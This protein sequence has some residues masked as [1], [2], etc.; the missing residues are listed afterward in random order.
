MSLRIALFLLVLLV[1]VST[2]GYAEE[3]E[4]IEKVVTTGIG[5]D[6][7]RAKQNAIRNA[8]EQVIGSYVSSDT[9][10]KNSQLLK[11]EILSY[12]GGYLKEMKIISQGQNDDGLFAVQIEAVVVSTKLKRKIESLNIATKKVEGKSLFGEAASKINEQKDASGLLKN[13]LSKYPQAA[14]DIKVG[15]PEIKSTD[16][17]KN[18][19]KIN[20]PLII[21]WDSNFIA[22]LEDVLSKISKE[23]LKMEDLSGLIYKVLSHEEMR[24]GSGNRVVCFSP[25][26][27]LK[28]RKAENCKIID[29]IAYKEATGLTRHK[30]TVSLMSTEGVAVERLSLTVFLKDK[31]DNIID[32]YI[33]SFDLK[34]GDSSKRHGIWQD[35]KSGQLDYDFGGN[36]AAAN[37]FPNTLKDIYAITLLITDGE[38][39]MDLET[40]LD[41]KYLENISTIDVQFEPFKK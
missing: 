33:Y 5:V 40:D 39:N 24:Y 20:I 12:S 7:D 15:K 16:P 2:I 23:N 28:S 8:V 34:D 13:I 25:K 14:Y 32:T 36:V 31:D 1:F 4:K 21:K 10:V 29:F 27:I 37:N 18:K 38:Y 35:G 41:V 22:E 17:G 30:E 3:A 9:I 19:A 11:D 6:I 26:A